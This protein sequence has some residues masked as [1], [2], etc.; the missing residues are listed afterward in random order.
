MFP[1]RAVATLI[2]V[3]SAAGSMGGM[4]FPIVVGMA[5]DRF[6]NGYTMIFG[7]CSMAYL[8]AF[9]LNHLLAPRFEPVEFR[10][11]A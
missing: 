5:L 1:K 3:G 11:A 6:A 4:I 8:A 9:A 2:G 7:Y 10:T